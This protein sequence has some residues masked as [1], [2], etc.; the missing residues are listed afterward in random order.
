MANVKRNELSSRKLRGLPPGRHTDGGGLMFRVHPSGG[1][2]WVLRLTIGDK[3]RHFGLG[4]YPEVGLAEAR[5]R[6]AEMRQRARSGLDPSPEPEVRTV[7]PSFAEAAEDVI[8]LR[9]PTWTSERHATQWR[10]SLRLHVFPHIG[11]TPVDEIRTEHMLSLLRPLWTR[12]AETARRVRQRC[13]VI[14]DYAVA[15]GWRTDNPC[16]GLKNALPAQSRQRRHHPAPHYDAVPGVV[17]NIL[18]SSSRLVTKLALTFCI[19]TAARSGEVR[20]AEWSEIDLRTATWN[21]PP[22]HTKQ[23]RLHRVALSSSARA[24]LEQATDLSGGSGLIFPG[25]SGKPL[26]NMS[27]AMVLRRLGYADIVPHGLSRATF[28]SWSLE[29]SADW[30]V[31]E[32]ALGHRLGGGEVG[33][34]VRTDQLEARRAVMEGWGRFVYPPTWE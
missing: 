29:T 17:N 23:R 1:R 34:Y 24:I 3:R 26:S 20:L 12:R 7:T 31:V 19:L 18:G 25:R 16:L 28:K 22:S 5:D 11:K 21:V 9:S 6:A 27:F 4:S 14:F 30:S 2:S 13:S 33:P 15:A 10:E 8:E 32:Q